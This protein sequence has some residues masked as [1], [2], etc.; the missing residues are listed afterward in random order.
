MTPKKFEVEIRKV[1]D[2]VN[3]SV[4][5]ESIDAVIKGLNLKSNDSV[6]AVAG[7][8]DH[9]FA[10]LEYAGEVKVI[11][12]N[13][14]QIDLVMLRAELLRIGRYDLF[15]TKRSTVPLN[16]DKIVARKNYF[17]KEGRLEKIAENL[18]NL[19]VLLPTDIFQ[20]P[21]NIQVS[22]MYLSNAIGY[23][24]CKHTF[25]QLLTAVKNLLP[26][27]LLYVSNSTASIYADGKRFN[28]EDCIIPGL[29]KDSRLTKRAR[30]CENNIDGFCWWPIVYRKVEVW[31]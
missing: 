22:K 20:T 17:S 14:F 9:A 1:V 26:G 10:M 5:N 12:S 21:L 25:S 16:D 19:V 27:G 7:S 4:T 30:E 6:L 13:P 3:Y 15:F 28:L 24:C 23:L 29:K 18:E 31:K 2:K 8:G 11:D